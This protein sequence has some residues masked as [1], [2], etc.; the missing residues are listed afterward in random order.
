MRLQFMSTFTTCLGPS[1]ALAFATI[2]LVTTD[3][4]RG[5]DVTFYAVAKDEGFDQS[6]AG[7]P[8]PK[9]NPFRF[10]AIVGL[11]TANSV[12]SATVRMLP[13]GP[14][15]PLVAG[16]DS[17]EFQ[18]KFLTLADLN[19]AAPN[20]T[21][22]MVIN[23]VHDGAHT[24][25]LTLNGDAYP[26]TN[27]QISNFT[28]AQTINPAAAFTLTWD[29]FS[30]GTANDF[31]Q[32]V[33]ADTFGDTL[34]KTPDPGQAGVLSGTATSVVIPANT[35]PVSTPLRGQLLFARAVAVDLT[36]YPGVTGFASYYKFTQFSLAT[37]G[38]TNSPPPKLVAVTPVNPSQF[39]LQLIG[40]AGLQYVIEASASLQ[41]GSWTPVITNTAVGG[42]FNFTDSRSAS[43]PNRFYRC[44]TIN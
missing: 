40:Q 20:G 6:G 27:P 5:A 3:V 16:P 41:S 32:L 26:S 44:R 33:V 11:A 25:S 24:I 7:A 12:S 42:Q 28:A 15:Y 22:Q 30:G 17:F 29:A 38:V 2:T 39:Q 34:L 23:G 14:I 4:A 37:I 18:A 21:Y 8:T 1:L 31:V 10:N 43:F 13:S 35:L 36:T 19:A 9:G